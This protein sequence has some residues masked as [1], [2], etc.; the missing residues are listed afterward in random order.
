MVTDFKYEVNFDLQG[1]LEA[2]VASE[3]EVASEA[4]VASETVIRVHTIIISK[5]LI[6]T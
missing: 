4:V 1:C 3:A 5:M 6:S 2:V